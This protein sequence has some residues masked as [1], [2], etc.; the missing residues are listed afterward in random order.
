MNQNHIKKN[1]YH[2]AALRGDE[3]DPRKKN[4]RRELPQIHWDKLYHA[5]YRFQSF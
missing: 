2:H 1:I 4:K 3:K 5:N